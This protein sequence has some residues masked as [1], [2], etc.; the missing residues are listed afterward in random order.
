MT[1]R[2]FASIVAILIGIGGLA[3]YIGAGAYDMGADAPHWDITRNA[4]EIVQIPALT[5]GKLGRRLPV[6]RASSR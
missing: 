2:W 6:R 4:I 1:K 5:E 3:L